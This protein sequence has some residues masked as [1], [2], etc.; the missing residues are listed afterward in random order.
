MSIYSATHPLEPEVRKG[1]KGPE[2]G[3]PVSIG[4]DCFIGGNV[5]VCPGVS[6]GDGS[7]VGAGSVV[8]KD[9]E[10]RVV[11]AGNPARVVRRL[12][13]VAEK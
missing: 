12:G 10:R 11:V 8:T 1:T 3:K 7:T 9:V 6:V 4:E 2:S 5:V 13:P